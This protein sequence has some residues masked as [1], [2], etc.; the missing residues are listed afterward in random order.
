[1]LDGISIIFLRK[2]PRQNLAFNTKTGPQWKDWKSSSQI[3]QIL[4]VFFKLI[5]KI[6]G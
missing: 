1:M 6:L 5:A 3:S 2:R 4:A